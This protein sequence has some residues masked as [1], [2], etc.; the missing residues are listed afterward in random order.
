M[1]TGVDLCPANDSVYTCDF[2]T[3]EI[4]PPGSAP[5]SAP[6]DQTVL[7]GLPAH[8]FEVVTMSLVLNYLPSPDH[9]E[10]MISNA[11]KLLIVPSSAPD[12]VP[13]PTP[14]SS[15]AATAAGAGAGAGAGAASLPLSSKPHRTGLLLL[16]EK[17]S[18]FDWKT[19]QNTELP[20]PGNGN[21]SG[22]GSG[23]SSSAESTGETAV[24]P[25]SRHEWTRCICDLGFELVTYQTNVYAGH[26]V[27]LFAFRV[28]P[29]DRPRVARSAP[30]VA[31]GDMQP[32]ARM[33]IKTDV[34]LMP[35]P[36]RQ[37]NYH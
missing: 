7:L 3:I 19:P 35:P 12:E 2:L 1:Y 33:L 21:G 17:I 11:R 5:V 15:S 28:V 14:T 37:I 13:H 32:R 25:P 30:P 27:H 23:S 4:G 18:I 36:E 6:D 29:L 9:R 34:R 31:P 24:T 10:L 8:S 22:S 20:P 26:H 16:V